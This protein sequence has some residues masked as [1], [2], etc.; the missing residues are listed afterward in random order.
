MTKEELI[1]A[2]LN[3]FTIEIADPIAVAQTLFKRYVS[4]LNYDKYNREDHIEAIKKRT[5]AL[6]WFASQGFPGLFE[7]L[8][9]TQTIG[10]YAENNRKVEEVLVGY[11]DYYLNLFIDR[12]REQYWVPD[13]DFRKQPQSVIDA[14]E[15]A[16]APVE[17]PAEM[18]RT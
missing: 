11:E 12:G 5:K 6:V 14:Y 16:T 13:F 1:K 9:K 15:A 10:L 4:P 2:I 3:K 7:K 8:E 17:A 18:P